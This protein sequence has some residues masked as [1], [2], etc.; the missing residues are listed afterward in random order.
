M[1]SALA[2]ARSIATQRRHSLLASWETCLTEYRD[3]PNSQ[4]LSLGR[5]DA[6]VICHLSGR[7]LLERLADVKRRGDVSKDDYISWG[8]AYDKAW[9]KETQASTQI[10][11]VTNLFGGSHK[12]LTVLAPSVQPTISSAMDSGHNTELPAAVIPDTQDEG[13]RIE[14]PVKPKVTGQRHGR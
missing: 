6:Q 7:Y 11:V 8:I 13:E 9:G 2:D 5:D 12:I 14:L 10:N 4:R 3:S 1:N